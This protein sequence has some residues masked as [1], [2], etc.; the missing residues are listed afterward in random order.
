MTRSFLGPAWQ[1]DRVVAV[2]LLTAAALAAAC[3]RRES[4]V[5]LEGAAS[6]SGATSEPAPS[7]A[8]FAMEK[9]SVAADATAPPSITNDAAAQ[10]GGDSVITPGM[11]I[12][13]GVASVEVDSLEA[14]VASVTELARRLGGYI[15]NT[16]METGK[17]RVR[18][19]TLDDQG[20]R[21]P[22]RRGREWTRSPRQGRVGLHDDGGRG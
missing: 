9:A 19:A 4:P 3:E 17:L 6:M 16:S 20:P 12:R 10:A 18:T 5:R 11:I 13:N 14:A 21:R 2:L 15:A 22:L 7:P 1:R 8:R